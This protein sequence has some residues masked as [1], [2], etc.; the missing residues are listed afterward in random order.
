M[1]APA[2]RLTAQFRDTLALAQAWMPFIQKGALFVQTSARP[3]LGDLAFV[4]VTLEATG[5]RHAITGP[6]VWVSPLAPEDG[7]PAGVGIQLPD[8]EVGQRL[9]SQIE[10]LL[11]NMQASLKKTHTL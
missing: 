4:L 9:A 8:D 7:H 3:S 6:I 1:N 5:Q 10:D 2:I 11:G